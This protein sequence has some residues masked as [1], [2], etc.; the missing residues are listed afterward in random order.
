MTAS[1]PRVPNVLATR[2]ASRE[3]A[4]NLV[5]EHKIVLERR[6]WVAVLEAQRD[7][8]IDVGDQAIEAYRNVIDKVDL[9]SIDARERSPVHDVK[10]RIEEFSALAGYS[11]STRA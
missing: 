6:L 7:L 1:D 8:G 10:A 5:P 4:R 9:D 2:Y 11:T 3:M